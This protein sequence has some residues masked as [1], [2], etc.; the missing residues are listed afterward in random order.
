MD[1]T[2][3]ASQLTQLAE[4]YRELSNSGLSA[5]QFN[6]RLRRD[7]VSALDASVML[8]DLYGLGLQECMAIHERYL[9]ASVDD[10]SDAD[11]NT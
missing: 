5:D 4:R 11:P 6:T 7:G 10:V 1:A 8:R 3:H 9:A 2:E